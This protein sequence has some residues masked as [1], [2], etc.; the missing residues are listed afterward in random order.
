MVANEEFADATRIFLE[1]RDGYDRAGRAAREERAARA[2]PT[3]APPPSTTPPVREAR[4]PT[5]PPRAVATPA[6]TAAAP[7]PPAPTPVPTPVVPARRF[8]GGSTTVTTPSAGELAGFESAD[9]TTRKPPRF[10]G[11]MEFEVLPPAVRPGEPFVVRVHLV[12]ESR[13]AVKI[14]GVEITTIA[15][16][17]RSNAAARVLQPRVPARGRALVAEHSAVWAPART[18]SLVAVATVEGEERVRSRLRS[19]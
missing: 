5:P 3:P 4:R 12:N 10:V 16:G 17:E 19:E 14:E 6:S 7:Q 18:W 11:Q 8:V 15:D 13:K 2:T 1:A 9:V